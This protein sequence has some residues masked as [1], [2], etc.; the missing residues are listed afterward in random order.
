M[1]RS[2]LPAA[3]PGCPP[4]AVRHRRRRHPPRR[5]RRRRA[6]P[7]R[8]AARHRLVPDDTRRLR[9]AA[10]WLLGF[11]PVVQV[12]V[13]GHQQL[14]RRP[15]PSAAGR[16]ASRRRGRP[17]EP[18][19]P[20]PG[21]QVRHPR[22]HRRGPRRAGRRSPRLPKTKDGNVEGIRVLGVARTSSV[23]ARTQAMNQLR[24]LVST[25][26]AELREQLRAPA[27]QADRRGL[28]RPSARRGQHRRDH[29]Q[30]RAADSWPGGSS[31]STP[32]SPSSTAA[33]PLLVEQV[34]PAAARGV[35]RRTAHRRD[36]AGHRRGQPRAT[37][38]RSDLRPALRRRADPHRQR[39]DQR[40]PPAPPRR[41]P[42]SQQRPVDHRAEPHGDPPRDG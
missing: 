1:A 2:T 25:A 11:G 13:E 6:G 20:P 18:A 5:P 32:R 4:T 21:R 15:D 17:A 14:R 27:D 35:R 24:S 34:A 37:P 22:R 41:R 23:K 42:T 7:D 40:L 12:G 26:P 29:H 8:R 10:D 39:Q 38:Q 36:A 3:P 28:R 30:D 9:A 19:G 31:T 16:R 33:A